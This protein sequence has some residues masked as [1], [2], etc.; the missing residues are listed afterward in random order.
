MWIFD[1]EVGDLVQ[2]RTHGNG[3]GLVLSV[4]KIKTSYDY[5]PVLFCEVKWADKTS[6]V[7]STQLKAA[8]DA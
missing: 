5:S 6:V 2:H 8:Y 4:E 3:I 7:N 1:V